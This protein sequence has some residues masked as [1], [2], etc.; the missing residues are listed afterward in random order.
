MK[1]LDAELDALRGGAD[2]AGHPLSGRVCAVELD[3]RGVV[4]IAITTPSTADPATLVRQVLERAR[5]ERTT[6]S[7]SV[8]RM[9]PVHA[10]SYARAEDAAA[11]AAPLFASELGPDR[12][13]FGFSILYRSRNNTG[14][15]RED[16]LAALLPLVPPHNHVDLKTFDVAI[17][18]EICCKACFVGVAPGYTELGKLN[19]RS[20]VE[21]AIA[22][23]NK[24]QLLVQQKSEPQRTEND[25]SSH[26]IAEHGISDESDTEK[27]AAAENTAENS[28]AETN[29]TEKSTAEKT[30]VNKSAIDMSTPETSTAGDSA[31]ENCAAKLKNARARED[32]IALE[33]SNGAARRTVSTPR[34]DQIAADDVKQAQSTS[35]A[36]SEPVHAL[37]AAGLSTAAECDQATTCVQNDDG[38]AG[39]DSARSAQNVECVLENSSDSNDARVVTCAQPRA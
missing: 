24:Q 34:G 15:H 16:F 26:I 18:V 17:L 31:A 38:T 35:R 28:T 11:I 3:V 20:V 21:Q 22:A 23:L 1:A 25:A 9:L 10:T 19:L 2:L 27:C 4:F 7:R 6:R 33:S 39:P 14:V 13:T 8:I 36:E 37:C 30:A 32:S 29:A 12:G 5:E